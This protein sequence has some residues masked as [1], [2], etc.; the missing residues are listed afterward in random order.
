MINKVYRKTSLVILKEEFAFQ[1]V[2]LW[3]IKKISMGAIFLLTH[4]ILLKKYRRNACFFIVII[5]AFS[6]K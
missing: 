5:D 4:L 1:N 3:D 2:F 6:G